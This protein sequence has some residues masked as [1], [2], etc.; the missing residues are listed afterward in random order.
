M[1]KQLLLFV[2]IL[3]ISLS[4]FSQK[5]DS[6]RIFSWKITAGGAWSS[7]QDLKYS[8]VHWT[9]IGFVP[10]TSLTWQKKGIHGVGIEGSI[11]HENP[12]TFSGLGKTNVYRG[13]VYYYY[14]HPVKHRKNCQLFLGAKLD[15][16][17]VNWRIIDGLSNNASYLIYGTNFKA[18]SNYQRKLNDKWQVDAQLG[19]QLFSFMED[20]MSF[21]Y[22]APQTL[23]EKGEYNYDKM[24]LP[25]YFTPFWDYLNIET[26]F[27]FSYGRRWVFSYLWRMQQSY[28]VKGYRLTSGYSAITVSY[29]IMSKTKSIS[30]NKNN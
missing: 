12:K 26:N 11:G 25:V 19:F 2:F 16:L 5:E 7:F 8:D 9:G 13:Q 30:K 22:A 4:G 24:Q 15:V 17:D 10:A 27:H 23:L 28:L 18:F 20:G 14:L 3:F 29:K 1:K 21:A 6:T